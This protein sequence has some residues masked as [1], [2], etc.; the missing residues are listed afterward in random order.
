MNKVKTWGDALEFTWSTKWK[1]MRSAKTSAIN[2]A[3]VT[4]YAGRSLPLK[5]MASAGWW[6][7]FQSELLDQ[8]RS[9]GGVNRIVSAGT[10][11]M[12]YTRLAGMHENDCPKFSRCAE[13]EARIH[14]FKKDEVDRMAHLARDLWSDRWGDNLADAILVSAYTGVRQAELLSL[15]PEDYDPALDA[16]IIGGKPW[17]MTKSGKVRQLPVNDKIRPIIK[18]RLSQSR[19]FSADWNNKDQLYGAFKKVRLA[20]QIPEEYV[21]HCLRHS[22][23]TWV[24]AVTHPRTLM[25]LLGHSTIEQSLKYCKASDE[26]ARSAILAI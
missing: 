7:Q 6:I 23:G 1:R 12:K 16:L 13:N 24:G 9:G 5:R 18:N 17:N 11:V 2:A 14:W 26:A 21:W 8:H 3:H 20:A 22:F 4:E 15:R 25:E 19:L 10:T